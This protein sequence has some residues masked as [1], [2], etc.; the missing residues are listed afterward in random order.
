[1]RASSARDCRKVSTG[2]TM[3]PLAFAMIAFN[4]DDA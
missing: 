3:N 4:T 2:L 1:V